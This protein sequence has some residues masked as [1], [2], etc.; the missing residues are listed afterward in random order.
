MEKKHF[1]MVNQFYRAKVE[2]MSLK[3][4]IDNKFDYF[5]SVNWDKC[6]DGKSQTPQEERIKILQLLMP[7]VFDEYDD[8]IQNRNS[9]AN[10]R[11]KGRV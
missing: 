10:K 1:F 7:E 2:K 4:I 9:L 3:F 5:C 8:Q 6:M 11:K